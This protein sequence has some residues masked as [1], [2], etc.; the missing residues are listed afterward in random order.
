VEVVQ[1]ALRRI[2]GQRTI[3]VLLNPDDI[4]SVSAA[5]AELRAFGCKTK[6]APAV[7]AEGPASPYDESVRQ[8]DSY[9][10]Y[11]RR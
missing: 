5:L 3:T 7:G 6:Q 11:T 2:A 4:E 8:C 1:G 10:A 9:W